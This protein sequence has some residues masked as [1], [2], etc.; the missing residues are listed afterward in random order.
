M[1]LVLSTV[2]IWSI[3]IIPFFPL[4]FTECLVWYFFRFV[5]IGG[6]TS[7]FNYLF[8]SFGETMT[9]GLVFFISLPTVGSRFTRTTEYCFKSIPQGFHH[10]TH[11]SSATCH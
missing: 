10:R 4:C 9:Q 3:A 1:I 11:R 2:R 7:V 5:V 6:R 8:I